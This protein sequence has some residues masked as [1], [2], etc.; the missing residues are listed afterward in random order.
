MQARSLYVE[1]RSKYH[2]HCMEWNAKTAARFGLD[3][4]IPFMD[5]DLVAFLMSVPGEIQNRDGVPRALLRAAMR[6]VLPEAVR[7]RTS[8]PRRVST[9]GKRECAIASVRRVSARL[10]RRWPWMR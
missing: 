9:S 3:A 4:A 7:Q 5:R 10:A 2:V 1:A 6:G 8:V